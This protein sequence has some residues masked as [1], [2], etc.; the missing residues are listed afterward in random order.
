MNCSE[1]GKKAIVR[2]KIKAEITE[3]CLCEECLNEFHKKGVEMKVL[4]ELD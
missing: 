1:C 3:L 2:V 4:E